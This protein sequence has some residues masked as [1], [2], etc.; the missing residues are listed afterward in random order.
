MFTIY[1]WL[2]WDTPAPQS[3]LAL[4]DTIPPADTSLGARTVS[5]AAR[6]RVP[7][8]MHAGERARVQG[9]HR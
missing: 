5:L 2:V 3:L 6:V 4:H 8:R 1:D 9:L 7:A